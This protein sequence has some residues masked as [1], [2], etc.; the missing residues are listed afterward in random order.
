[1]NE[2][3]EVALI[4]MLNAFLTASSPFTVSL[5]PAFLPLLDTDPLVCDGENYT[6]NFNA[7]H[8]HVKEGAD[9]EVKHISSECGLREVQTELLVFTL[10]VL[11]R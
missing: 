3:S 4:V 6:F 2:E 11:Q 8:F 7:C 5:S 10:C 9:R 1:M